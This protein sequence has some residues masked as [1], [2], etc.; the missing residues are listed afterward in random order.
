MRD[1][2]SR[3]GQLH[4][5][6][7]FARQHSQASSGLILL[8]CPKL[9]LAQSSIERRHMTPAFC[10]SQLGHPCGRYA[11]EAP[12][13][14]GV[15]LFSSPHLCARHRRR[16]ERPRAHLR[17]NAP[18]AAA[19]RRFMAYAPVGSESREKEPPAPRSFL[20]QHYKNL[21]RCVRDSLLPTAT[22][23]ACCLLRGFE[24]S[25]ICPRALSMRVINAAPSL[26]PAALGLNNKCRPALPM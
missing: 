18:F 21:R 6:R 20:F 9:D 4:L 24:F 8:S 12:T 16:V 5:A 1:P 7:T 13:C 10:L 17:K 26:C 23:A 3:G 19:A 25:G 11:T 14:V 15:G 2:S 22:A